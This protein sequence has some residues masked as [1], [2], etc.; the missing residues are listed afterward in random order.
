[1]RLF[2]GG[3][4]RRVCGVFMR[5]VCGVQWG[6]ESV[7]EEIEEMAS[8]AKDDH[9]GARSA[10][11][12]M[13]ARFGTTESG[14]NG[15]PTGPCLPVRQELKPKPQPLPALRNQTATSASPRSR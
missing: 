15:G 1:M 7:S 10:Q 6:Q 12:S 2:C 13:G 5:R 4:V 8:Q 9:R 14:L 3:L 11:R